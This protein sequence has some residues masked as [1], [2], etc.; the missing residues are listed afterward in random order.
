ME[1]D[2]HPT[3]QDALCD[4][5]AS[6]DFAQTRDKARRAY[7]DTTVYPQPTDVFRAFYTTPFDQVRVVILGQDP[8][9]GPGQAM[10]LAFSVPDGVG[11][12][13]SLQNIYKEIESDTGVSSQCLP[14]GDLSAWA[15]Q[16]VLLL[17]TTL[18]VEAHQAASHAGFGWQQMTD[19]AIAAISREH[20]HVVFMLWGAHAQSKQSLIDSDKHCILVAPHPSPLSAHR[21]FFGCK[22]FSQCNDYLVGCGTSPIVW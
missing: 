3:W 4:Y 11:I 15:D 21:G 10:G 5:L 16:G 20:E 8:Y 6:P 17:N 14:G 19:A 9:H 2:I 1:I 12:P 7:M 18:T 22:H 13:P